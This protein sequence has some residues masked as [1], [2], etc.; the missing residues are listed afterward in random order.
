MARYPW[1]REPPLVIRRRTGVLL[2]DQGAARLDSAGALLARPE[3]TLTHYSTTVD[4]KEG[5]DGED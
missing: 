5:D 2:R 4:K 3:R 1:Q